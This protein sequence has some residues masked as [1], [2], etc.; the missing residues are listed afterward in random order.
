MLGWARMRYGFLPTPGER[1]RAAKFDV[2]LLLVANF[3]DF[4]L[5][6]LSI[7]VVPVS[8]ERTERA[9]LGA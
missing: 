9:S 3:P 2:L 8:A 6:M 5:A 7:L 4:V 1:S